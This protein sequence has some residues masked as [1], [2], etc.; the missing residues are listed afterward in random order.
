MLNNLGGS[1]N[2]DVAKEFFTEKY[3]RPSVNSFSRER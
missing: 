3:I 2:G 1:P